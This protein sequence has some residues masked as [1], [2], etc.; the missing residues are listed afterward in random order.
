MR[1]LA[2]SLSECYFS[3]SKDIRK[4]DKSYFLNLDPCPHEALYVGVDQDVHH[5]N[6]SRNI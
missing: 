5:N 2:H 1:T 6:D 4:A 3:L